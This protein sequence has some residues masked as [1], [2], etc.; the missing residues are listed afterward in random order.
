MNS[1]KFTP[2][3]VTKLEKNQIFV[4]GS[5]RQSK[6]GKG[7]ALIAFKKFGAIYGQ[8]EGLQGQSYA[9]ITKEL[10]SNYPPVTLDDVERGVIRF[11]KFAEDNPDLEFL[12]VKIGCSLAGF[13]IEDIA[14]I[15]QRN[16]DLNVHKNVIL[17]KDFWSSFT[18]SL[19]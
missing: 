9:I 8:P 3:N 7:A 4:F 2:D 13:K 5:N 17:P 11:L 10:R 14:A 15:F 1:I 19:F 16:M 18:S 6:H 12:V